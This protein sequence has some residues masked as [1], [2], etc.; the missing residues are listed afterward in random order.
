MI[1]SAIN[2]SQN[3]GKA[4]EWYLKNVNLGKL[5]LIVGRNAVGKTRAVNIINAIAR[6]LSAKIPRLLDGNWDV[7]FEHNDSLLRYILRID[8]AKV[9]EER[10]S[11]N[12]KILLKRGGEEGEYFSEGEGYR[13]YYPPDDKLTIQVRRDKRELP[14]LEELIEW[15]EKYRSFS[16]T[17]VRPNLM[18]AR[19]PIPTGQSGP[20]LSAEDLGMAPYLLD[21]IQNNEKTKRRII[22]DL[23]HMGY[24]VRDLASVVSSVPGFPSDIRSIQITEDGIDFPIGQI[25]L[26]QGMYR[27]IAILVTINYLMQEGAE[28]TIVIDD[29][30]EGIDFERSSRLIELIFKRAEDTGI[31]LIATSNDRF[32]M[33]SV[34]IKYWNVFERKRNTVQAFNYKNSKEA[35]DEF[36]LTGLNNFDFFADK[37]YRR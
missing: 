25:S 36:S 1:I 18:F 5:N 17:N 33:N 15:A 34:D 28:G 9:V 13:K 14:Y 11:Q 22:K 32:L 8:G 6:L 23:A 20:D 31:Q 10:L 2:Y 16:F 29:I 12:E 3:I 24:K 21:T 37:L 7:V 4:D 26:S 35:F 30:G 27:V 19:L